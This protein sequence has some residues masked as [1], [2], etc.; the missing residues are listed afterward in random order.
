MNIKEQLIDALDSI[1]LGLVMVWT[2]AIAIAL[3]NPGVVH[4]R[5]GV[6]EIYSLA[7]EPSGV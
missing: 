5:N 7:S 2:I 4:E 3:V 1:R 6:V